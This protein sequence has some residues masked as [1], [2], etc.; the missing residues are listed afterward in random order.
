MNKLT[1]TIDVNAPKEKVWDA[2]LG[3]KTYIEWTE[4]F[5]KGSY[6]EGNWEK[7]SEIKFL[8]E[9]DGKLSGMY[10]RIAEN[11]PYAF[12]SI[13]HLGE[14]IDGKVDTKSERGRQWTGSHENY[15]FTESNGVTTVKVDLESGN[16]S[17][18]FEKM[19]EGMW[20]KALEKLKEVAER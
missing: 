7:G 8:A 4:V 5:H 6:F 1:Y 20:P 17:D 14:I 3:D 19:F 2:M 16:I 18:E 15:V 9:D 11:I 12:V 13:E 10:S